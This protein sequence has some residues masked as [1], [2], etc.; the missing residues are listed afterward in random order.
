MFLK[1]TVPI[2]DLFWP[3]SLSMESDCV[4]EFNVPGLLDRRGGS[5]PPCHLRLDLLAQHEEATGVRSSGWD[6][7]SEQSQ[8]WKGKSREGWASGKK[9]APSLAVAQMRPVP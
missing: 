9:R 2:L 6:S 8:S 5:G 3:V 7:P 1:E 4:W